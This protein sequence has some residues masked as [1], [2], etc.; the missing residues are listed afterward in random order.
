[1][2]SYYLNLVNDGTG[3]FTPVVRRGGTASSSGTTLTL[4]TGELFAGSSTA[5]TSTKLIGLAIDAS[6]RAVINDYVSNPTA[7]YYINIT[8]DGASPQPNFSPVARRNGTA[9]SGG[10]ALTL[11]K[12]ELFAGTTATTTRLTGLA[13]GALKRAVLNDRAAGN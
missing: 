10:T 3:L 12:G 6:F 1:M 9:S 13:V 5:A 4:P 8:D 7:S 2:S 11:P